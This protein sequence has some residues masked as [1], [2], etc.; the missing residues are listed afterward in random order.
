MITFENLPEIFLRLTCAMK[1]RK[2]NPYFSSRRKLRGV[3][4]KIL[5]T[6]DLNS[7]GKGSK[8]T[9]TALC[10]FGKLV[11]RKFSAQDIPIELNFFNNAAKNYKWRTSIAHTR[12]W[13]RN[14]RMNI[15][16]KFDVAKKS[17]ERRILETMLFIMNSCFLVETFYCGAGIACIDLTTCT[18]KW[19]YDC[20]K[21]L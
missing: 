3:L 15:V 7:Y 16:D 1:L 17:L 12:A 8:N 9:S 19:V 4:E 5:S 18:S 21:R 2:L 6:R 14:P 20:D 10:F 11:E 13:F